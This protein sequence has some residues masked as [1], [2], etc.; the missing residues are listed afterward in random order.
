MPSRYPELFDYVYRISINCLR[1]LDYMVE[2]ST[3]K[4]TIVFDGD[5]AHIRV[6]ANM[7]PPHYYVRLDYTYHGRQIGYTV[8][9]VSVASNLG[10]GRIWYFVCPRTG[11]RCRILYGVDGYFLHRE[12]F[13]EA[14][15][16][17]QTRSR[18]EREIA[19]LVQLAFDPPPKR[20]RYKGKL[21]RRYEV[22]LSKYDRLKSRF[23]ENGGL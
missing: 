12:A 14:V 8:D 23:Q 13:P 11:K 5:G 2:G 7:C 6:E 16:E 9:L 20:K 22:W 4:G 21:T 1:R 15:Y 10:S 19:A 17:V 3:K 18:S